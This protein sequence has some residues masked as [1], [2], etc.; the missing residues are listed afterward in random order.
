M[1]EN[2]DKGRSDPRVAKHRDSDSAACMIV[3]EEINMSPSS[4]LG[5]ATLHRPANEDTIRNRVR[6]FPGS[7][8]RALARGGS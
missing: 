1:K 8:V 7:T 4:L 6:P 3:A 2:A 5:R